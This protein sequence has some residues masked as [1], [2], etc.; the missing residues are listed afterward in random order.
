LRRGERLRA[1]TEI[2]QPSRE[3][4]E[5]SGQVGREGVWAG[6]GEGAA[7]ADR[8]FRSGDRFLTPAEIAQ[9]IRESVVSA[10][11]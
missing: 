8:F 3:I 6:L 4:G 9:R 11:D 10:A 7:R 5:R 1:P 2:A